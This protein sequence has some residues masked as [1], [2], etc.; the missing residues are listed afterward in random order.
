MTRL[1]KIKL[2]AVTQESFWT[3]NASFDW[4]VSVRSVYNPIMVQS[5]WT[6][7]HK[8]SSKPQNW[9]N[10]RAAE[11]VQQRSINKHRN[12]TVLL[13]LDEQTHFRIS[14]AG[15][16]LW[17]SPDCNYSVTWGGSVLTV[18]ITAEDD[19]SWLQWRVKTLVTHTDTT[20]DD[21][22]GSS[23]PT[24]LWP[25]PGPPDAASSRARTEGSSSASGR[26]RPRRCWET[27]RQ[28]N[29]HIYN[30]CTDVSVILWVYMS[31]DL[32]WAPPAVSTP[33]NDKSSGRLSAIRAERRW[34]CPSYDPW[35]PW[36]DINGLNIHR[37]VKD[38]CSSENEWQEQMTIIRA[39]SFSSMLSLCWKI[40]PYLTSLHDL[41]KEKL[42]F[43]VWLRTRETFTL[44]QQWAL[45]NM[46]F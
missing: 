34:C 8:T 40:T 6:K 10:H 37:H 21:V 17:P 25:S 32:T 42:V 20:L 35:P 45:G 27:R 9:A 38:G 1:S 26:S 19:A 22:P 16:D 3:W 15:R 28:I 7:T 14:A 46:W 12:N 41:W 2:N 31:S 18:N 5:T 30:V 36:G 23:R 43:S 4:C 24:S 39:F 44:M 13:T 29:M 33:H 11:P